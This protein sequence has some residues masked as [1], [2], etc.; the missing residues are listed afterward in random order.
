MLNF[1][2]IFK[3]LNKRI[4]QLDQFWREGSSDRKNSELFQELVSYK[5]P[6]RGQR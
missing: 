3:L 1:M 6:P 4:K 5:G 2:Y